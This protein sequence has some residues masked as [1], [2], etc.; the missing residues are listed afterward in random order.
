Y[1]AWQAALYRLGAPLG[2]QFLVQNPNTRGIE[3]GAGEKAVLARSLRR[4]LA[5]IREEPRARGLYSAGEELQLKLALDFLLSGK[6]GPAG[7]C[8]AGRSFAMLSPEG[9]FYLC[10]FHK[11]ITLGRVETPFHN[12]WTDANARR[13]HARAGRRACARCFLRCAVKV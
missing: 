1:A 10:P 12:F 8:G 2:V 11:D 5:E 3:Q 6:A 7:S 9:R 13:A 4:V